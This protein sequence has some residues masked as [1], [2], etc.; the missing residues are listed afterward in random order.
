MRSLYA[1]IVEDAEGNKQRM[2]A[3]ADNGFEIEDKCRQTMPHYRGCHMA[4]IEIDAGRITNQSYREAKKW[5]DRHT[6]C[7]EE[8]GGDGDG[9]ASN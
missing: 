5:L 6:D 3:I 4:I 1:V 9:P 8:E 2:V 7:V